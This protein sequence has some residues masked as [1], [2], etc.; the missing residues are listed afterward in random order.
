MVEF[1]VTFQTVEAQEDDALVVRQILRH[2]G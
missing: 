2:Q 1:P